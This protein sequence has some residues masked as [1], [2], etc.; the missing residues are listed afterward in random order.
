MP[1]KDRLRAARREAVRYRTVADRV[2]ASSAYIGT[3]N[4]LQHNPSFELSES[5][6]T[7]QGKRGEFG[8]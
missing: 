8:G 2:G 4:R 6:P 7:A 1:L 3:W 5:S